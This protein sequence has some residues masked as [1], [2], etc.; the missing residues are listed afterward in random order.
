MDA[1]L[2][3]QQFAALVREPS[4]EFDLLEACLLLAAEDAP[5]TDLDAARR[6][7]RSLRDRLAGELTGSEDFLH[8]AWA[9]RQVLCVEWGMRVDGDAAEVPEGMLLTTLLERRQSHPLVFAAL[10]RELARSLG[11][12]V[13]IV[14]L[15]GTVALMFVDGWGRTYVDPLDRANV[16][17]RDELTRQLASRLGERA[18]RLPRLLGELPTRRILV[19]TLLLLKR[20]WARRQQPRR[21]MAASERI[22]LL[23]PGSLVEQRDRGL[24]AREVG[25]RKQAIADLRGYL[26]HR[27]D[28]LDASRIARLLSALEREERGEA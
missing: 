21:A 28:A 7:L 16:V 17:T 3:R 11:L 22:L 12:P 9:L 1:H 14:A 10:Y 4:K 13:E 26:E 18:A 23:E 15:P 25:D 2:A 19:R 24:L 6:R 8:A 27:P 5:D 20:A